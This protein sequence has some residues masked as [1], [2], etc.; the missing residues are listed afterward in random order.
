MLKFSLSTFVYFRYTMVEAI[1]RIAS[2][3]FDAVEIWGGRPHAYAPDMDAAHLKEVKLALQEHDLRISNF[4]P[5]QFRYPV[6]LAI[7]DERI[8]Q[9]SLEY[10][11]QSID[12]AVELGSPYASVCPGFSIYPQTQTEAWSIL[13]NSLE[14]L[15]RYASGMPITLLLE[16]AHCMETD[17]VKT[18]DEGIELIHDLGKGIGLLPDTGH[19]FI[20]DESLAETVMKTSGMPC[21]WHIDDN[22]GKSDDHLIPG[23]G[24]IDFLPFFQALTK[25]GYQ[26]MIAVE[27]GYSYILDPDTASLQSLTTLKQI[28]TEAA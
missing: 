24:K 23:D 1:R 22:Q 26:G 3:G 25:S 7:G 16:P 14:T 13:H 11:K 6:N 28:A 9:G 20:N 4:I 8:R 21:H 12:M 10:L 5:A 18:V 15:V 27:L 2:L 19:L 17:L